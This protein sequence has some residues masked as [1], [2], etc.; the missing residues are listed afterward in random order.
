MPLRCQY[1]V[2]GAEL[3]A[4]GEIRRFPAGPDRCILWGKPPRRPTMPSEPTFLICLECETPCYIFEWDNVKDRLQEALCQVCGND[5]IELFQTE[6][7]FEG[8]A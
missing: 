7:E 4:W 6:E 8:E 1:Y 3:V 5:K 2:H